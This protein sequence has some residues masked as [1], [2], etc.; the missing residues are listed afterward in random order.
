M[1]HCSYI[2]LTLERA[3]KHALLTHSPSSPSGHHD[4]SPATVIITYY[5]RDP[6]LR[7]AELSQYCSELFTG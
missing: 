3:Q 4:K 6:C 5:V 2:V 1:L 7:L